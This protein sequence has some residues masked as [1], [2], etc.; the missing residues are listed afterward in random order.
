MVSAGIYGRGLRSCSRLRSAVPGA[1]GW[2]ATR[3]S[4]QPREQRSSLRLG[5]LCEQRKI[6]QAF[7]K[8]L[9]SFCQK[10]VRTCQM[11]RALSRAS[12]RVV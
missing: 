6:G 9:V 3:L 5:G 12:S 4:D 2:A 7:R 11:D 10:L 8:R 1:V